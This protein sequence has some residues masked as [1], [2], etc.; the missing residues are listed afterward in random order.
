MCLLRTPDGR[1]VLS[2]DSNRNLASSRTSQAMARRMVYTIQ[3]CMVYNPQIGHIVS[4][5]GYTVI[6]TVNHRI[7]GP[8]SPELSESY[9]DM[10]SKLSTYTFTLRQYT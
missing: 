7:C 6:H 9:S 3:R 10:A 8:G 4:G 2:R 5:F 1:L